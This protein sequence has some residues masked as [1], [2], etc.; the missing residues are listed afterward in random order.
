MTD[1]SA[2]L[3]I[4]FSWF[5]HTLMHVLVGLFLT[6]LLVLQKEWSMSYDEL[7]RLWTVGSILVAVIAPLAGYLGDRWSECR[8]MVIYFLVS[9]AGTIGCGLA[10][11][12]ESLGLSLALLGL[13]ASIYHPVGMSWVIR[14]AVNRGRS[15]GYLGL[16]GTIGVA[17]S[18]VIA[19]GL[20]EVWGWRSAF[21][22]PGVIALVAGFL[23]A[24]LIALGVI[25]DRKSDVVRQPASSRGDMVRAF[26]VLSATMI[27]SGIMFNGMQ[28]VLPKLFEAR[29]SGMVGE[30]TLGIGAL[31]TLVYLTAAAPQVLGGYLSDRYS[32]KWIYVLTLLGQAPVF[33]LMAVL[34]DL[35]LVIVAAMVI[36][37]S[38]IQIPAENLLLARYTPDRW[39]GV[40]FGAKFVLSFG[41]APVAVMLA[42][43]VFERTSDFAVL[44]AILAG[45]GMLAAI[46]ALLLPGSRREEG[47]PLAVPRPASS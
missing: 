26:F 25:E 47:V 37:C 41:A 15:M 6:I 20:S 35:P 46:S 33:G 28:V 11:G 21:L 2:R 43:T 3:S 7:I 8:M 40:A 38:Q 34:T 45:L 9:G 39:R 10:D 16:F 22:I 31:V 29:L 44:Y 13:G 23:L 27:C 18:A 36:I 17:T 12:P 4:G 5:G 14:H 19:G 32:L 42:A 1:S 24:S 30:G